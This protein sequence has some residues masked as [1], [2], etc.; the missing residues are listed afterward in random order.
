[1]GEGRYIV[2]TAAGKLTVQ[3]AEGTLQNQ[4]AV[5]ICRKGES[6][7]IETLGQTL[8]PPPSPS[9]GEAVILSGG[10]PANGE[11]VKQTAQLL[12][13]MQANTSLSAHS[14]HAVR[15]EALLSQLESLA[16]PLPAP[17]RE[18]LA[19]VQKQLESGLQTQQPLTPQQV[20][21]VKQCEELLCAF[22]Q[23]AHTPAASLSSATVAL[24]VQPGLI[25]F[26]KPATALAW[27]Q[28]LPPQADVLQPLVC[29]LDDGPLL[30]H[31]LE[32]SPQL[33]RIA[34][35]SP[36]QAF[37][38]L[39]HLLSEE[40]SHP[41]LKSLDAQQLLAMTR[42]LGALDTEQLRE[43][44]ALLGPPSSMPRF[45]S[46][47][48]QQRSTEILQWITPL[49]QGEIGAQTLAARPPFQLSSDIAAALPLLE[50]MV[51]NATGAA[52]VPQQLD[53]TV[54]SSEWLSRMVTQMGLDYEHRLSTHPAP[55]PQSMAETL[56]GRILELMQQLGGRDSLQTLPEPDSALPLVQR[57]L[58]ELGAPLAHL[59]QELTQQGVFAGTNAV[60]EKLTTS[61][62][63]IRTQFELLITNLTATQIINP[64]ELIQQAATDMVAHLQAILDE[65]GK[66]IEVPP[67][68]GEPDG[69]SGRLPERLQ[70]RLELQ[71]RA[72][73]EQVITNANRSAELLGESAE[74]GMGGSV[75]KL[76]NRF[77]SLQFLARQAPLPEGQQQILSIPVRM[78]N[79]LTDMTI[80]LVHHHQH[81]G[82]GESKRSGRYS[83]CIDVAPSIAGPC[84]IQMDY[85]VRQGIQINLRLEREATREWFTEHLDE[86]RTALAT[87]G[88]PSVSL[89]V[90]PLTSPAP[91]QSVHLPTMGEGVRGS[92]SQFDVHA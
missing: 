42:M 34:L 56:K 78:D 57:A 54:K 85:V 25:F 43:L 88:L 23:T 69:Q 50:Q 65:L 16:P 31:L 21:I 83:V 51:T 28:T 70:N 32:L 66:S 33:S 4:S 9:G 74:Q 91:V 1:L 76:L 61:L 71:I 5:L 24:S 68:R 17:L 37:A 86:L 15:L 45:E 8:P 6:L 55:I 49:L 22:I 59:Q 38:E 62:Q 30:L 82:G 35:L 64:R 80:R 13:E 58:L 63:S 77:E 75:E 3:L 41:L 67:G 47:T 87:L 79:Q 48:P 72:A 29:S 10:A 81:K 46:T 26:D 12:A 7:T 20:Q 19:E 89:R 11:V 44:D 18:S 60:L 39:H 84:S 2:Q 73:L 92:A 36:V 90:S 53:S 27:L 52:T 14:P 40:L